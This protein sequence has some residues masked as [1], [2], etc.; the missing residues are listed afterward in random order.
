M[1]TF[2]GH[3]P[4]LFG[5]TN[6]LADRGAPIR[7]LFTIRSFGWSAR[8]IEVDGGAHIF[9]ALDRLTPAGRD[10]AG[11]IYDQLAV[12]LPTAPLLNDPRRVLLREALLTRL[13]DHG[14]NRFRV[15][16]GDQPDA[17]ANF[18]VFVRE[19]SG[20]SGNLTELLDS[21]QALRRALR[22]L[23]VR[24][25]RP[26]DLLIVEYCHTADSDGLFR[27]YAAFKVGP[28]IVPCHLLAG[29]RWM[30][31]A[32]SD[33]KSLQI[34]EEELAYLRANP[35][36]DWLARVFALAGVDYGRIDYGVQAGVPQAWEIN[37][38]PTI[39]RQPGQPPRPVAPEVA[40]IREQARLAFHSELRAAFRALVP[41]DQPRSLRIELD[42]ALLAQ[43]AREAA[44]ER[45]R[46][47][48]VRFMVSSYSKLPLRAAFQR[49]FPNR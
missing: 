6:Y 47:A 33:T 40:P 4:G 26:A 30:M 35:H 29:R 41:A 31:K 23:R 5:I 13:A 39:G 22:A 9:A 21:P 11:G 27:K 19:T 45:R 42:P 24:G 15:C 16:R 28:A 36:R 2:W 10:A 18:P 25:R 34:A 46:E 32:E 12:Q 48:V 7:N 43:A 1:I 17:V 38:D 44:R 3:E 8:S 37:L 14:I 49:L 20:H